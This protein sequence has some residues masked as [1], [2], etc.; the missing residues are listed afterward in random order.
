M[1]IE[2]FCYTKGATARINVCFVNED[3][4]GV[5][6]ADTPESLADF[7]RKIVATQADFEPEKESVIVVMLDTRLSPFAWH[8]VSLGTVNES[9]C[10]PREV[11]RPVIVSGAAGFAILHNHPSGDPSPSRG[12]ERITRMMVEVAKIMDIQFI[13]HVIV[14][15]PAPG[16]ASYYSFREG[17]LIP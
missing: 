16:R 9:S 3:N 10:H 14:G 13:D 11:M 5:S 17:G 6:P 4:F 15:R 7:W 12:D 2:S 8:R 1:K